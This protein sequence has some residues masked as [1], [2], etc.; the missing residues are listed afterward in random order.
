MIKIENS[1]GWFIRKAIIAFLK[2]IF[3]KHAGFVIA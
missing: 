1:T 3:G 2:I